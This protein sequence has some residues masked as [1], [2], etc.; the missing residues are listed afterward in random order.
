MVDGDLP[1]TIVTAA[2]STDPVYDG[3]DPADVSVTNT[4]DDTA[5]VTVT[6]T[7]GLVTTEASGTASFTVML[8]SEPVA[9]V[10]ISLS[11]SETTEGTVSP[12][13]LT[14]A[15]TAWNTP[16]TVTVTGVDDD[17]A[18]GDLTYTIVTAAVST[19]PVYDG[20][21]PADVSVTNTDDDTAGVTLTPT[22]GLVTTEDG[23]TATFTVVLDSEPVADVTIG[24]SSSDTTEGTV[25]PTSL[26]FTAANW[27]EAQTVTVTGVDD[28]V[29]DGT[30][31]TPSSRR[32]RPAT[33][34]T[35]TGSTRSMSR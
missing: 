23:G 27:N 5:W 26:T 33:T 29:E 25:S 7:T 10:T 22:T 21:D 16:Q 2:A 1:Y 35:T 13:S 24:L 15:P 30:L 11:S 8:E 19:D 14:F 20:L 3:L 18:D 9:D 32:R 34:W 28:A 17:V 6:P 12:T 4:D 31:P